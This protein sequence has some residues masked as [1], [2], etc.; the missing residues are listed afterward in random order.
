M[1]DVSGSVSTGGIRA[2]LARRWAPHVLLFALALALRTAWVLAVDREG[3]PFNDSLFY[4]TTGISLSRGDGYVPLTGGPTARWPPRAPRCRRQAR[5]PNNQIWTRSPAR[6]ISGCGSSSRSSR[7]GAA[8]SIVD[9]KEH[10]MSDLIDKIGPDA[11]TAK[12]AVRHCPA[13]IAVT[14]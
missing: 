7:S 2:L 1:P 3:F 9:H 12:N 8:G 11:Q 6:F 5:P 10:A 13:S 14:W 4:H